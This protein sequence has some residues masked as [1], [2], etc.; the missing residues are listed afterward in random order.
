[1]GVFD[2]HQRGL[3]SP[4]EEGVEGRKGALVVVVLLKDVPE[5]L[6]GLRG[7]VEEW[8]ERS[9]RRERVAGTVEGRS[10]LLHHPAERRHQGGLAHPGFP[11]DE[12]QVPIPRGRHIEPLA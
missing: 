11:G 6:A 1:M 8:P 7:D 10:L 12:H 4:R 2:D 3:R 9:R 5:P